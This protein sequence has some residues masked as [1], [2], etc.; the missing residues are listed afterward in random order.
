MY[1]WLYCHL[2]GPRWAR[3]VELIV[4]ASAIIAFLMFVIFP[5]VSNIVSPDTVVYH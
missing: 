2:Y 4:I 5:W 1:Y 3:I